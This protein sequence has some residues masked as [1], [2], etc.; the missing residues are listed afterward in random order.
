MQSRFFENAVASL[1]AKSGNYSDLLVRSALHNGKCLSADVAA[2]LDPL[3]A[4]AHDKQNAPL[5]GCGVN[6]LKFSGSRGKSGAND[7]SAEF[8]AEV[9]RLFN[10]GGV[11]WQTGELGK[12]DFGGGG[13]IAAFTANLG[14]ETLDVGTALLCMHSP[15]EL[16]SKADIYHTYKAYE[17]F[18]K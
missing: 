8:V 18:F 16:A 9:R 6:I 12:V 3:Y 14:M 11:V 7:A 15:F 1:I 17:V 2:G 10:E 13:T 5:V 4:N